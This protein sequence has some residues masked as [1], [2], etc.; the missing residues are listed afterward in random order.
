MVK[1][2]E[3]LR[4]YAQ[5][6]SQ[7]GIVSSCSAS[8]NTIRDVIKKAEEKNVSWPLEKE[9]TDSALQEVLFPEKHASSDFRKRPDYEYIHKEL[10]K[11]S[12]NL[13]LL[14]DEYSLNCRSNDEIPY[15]YRQ[16][17]RFY[18]DYARKTKATMCIKRKPGELLEVDWAGQ[19]MTLTDQIT[20]EAIP[21]YIF[22]CALP[23]SQYAYVEGC[24]AMDTSNWI[25]A[26]I[27]AFQFYG[28]IPRIIVP[29]NLKTGVSKASRYESVIN[30]SYQEMAEHYRTTIVPARVRSPKDKAPAE[31]TV[32]HI[33]TWIIASLR[34]QTFFSLSEINR[35]IQAKLTEFNTKPFQKKKRKQVSGLH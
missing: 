14:W 23:C 31:S 32:G 20:G 7:R 28:G 22:V 26:H 10:A 35:E 8:R 12:V 11:P 21:V 9:W 25:G 15:S 24:L 19:T 17:C 34:D 6:V 3:I 30:L 5:G 33:S 1:Y 27:R 13:A 16:Y 2:R 4:L 18:H 29:D